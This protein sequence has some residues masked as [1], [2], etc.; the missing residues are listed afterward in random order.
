[1][2]VLIF[3]KRSTEA[4]LLLF[5]PLKAKDLN[6]PVPTGSLRNTGIGDKA[7][8]Q[9]NAAMA[10]E[11]KLT[12]IF[13]DVVKPVLARHPELSHALLINEKRP[14]AELIIHKQDESGFDVGI[15]CESHGVYPW[16]S[17]WHGGAWDA[18]TPY[19]EGN[20][21]QTCENCLGFIRTLL[22]T[23][24]R[25]RVQYKAGQ[26]CHWIVELFDGEHWKAQ[27][28]SSLV[29]YNYFGKLT[30]TIHQNR[31]FPSRRKSK[32]ET[33]HLWYSLWAD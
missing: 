20:L 12:D 1:L 23:D 17:N 21:Q 33:D 24:A 30:E 25:L 9:T 26:P 7:G 32:L 28:E 2:Q 29:I 3:R 18:T 13:L 27:E 4:W 6:S 22:S 8:S 31:H 10:D 16:A 5:A 19:A 14:R 15:I 11:K